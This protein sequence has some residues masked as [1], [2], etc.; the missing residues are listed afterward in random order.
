LLLDRS[1]H[2]A[3]MVASREDFSRRGRPDIVHLSLLLAL[4]SLVNRRGRLRIFVHTV[5]DFVVN[6]SPTVRI[7]RNYTRFVGL[8]EQ[9]L[10]H[11]RVPP[12][13]EPLLWTERSSLGGLLRSIG[14][15]KVI[16]L[17]SS[18]RSVAISELAQKLALEPN[19]AIVIGGFPR[20]SFSERVLSCL[21]E[22]L[23][24]YGEGLE[25][26]T[27]VAMVLCAV[28]EL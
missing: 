7:P 6:V 28:A 12:E 16:G 5:N 1:Y 23:S 20:G 11:G 18:G 15:S 10:A 17:S 14:P 2:H 22:L 9:L 4:D 13:G 25:T 26:W 8:M 3:A 27:V 19:P 24:I 21:Q